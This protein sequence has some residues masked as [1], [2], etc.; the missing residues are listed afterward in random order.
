M[1]IELANVLL[2]ILFFLVLLGGLAYMYITAYRRLMDDRKELL[3]R[4]IPHWQEAVDH[5]SRIYEK[6]EEVEVATPFRGD[7]GQPITLTW[8]KRWN[9][10]PGHYPNNLR[11]YRKVLKRDKWKMS[12]PAWRVALKEAVWP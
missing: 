7:D 3:P 1:S 11:W 6:G 12:A 4:N 8:S 9:P 5:L 2:A 10:Y